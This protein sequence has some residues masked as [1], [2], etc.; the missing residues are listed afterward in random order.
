MTYSYFCYMRKSQES[1]ERQML[2]LDSQQQKARECFPGLDLEFIAEARSARK[3]HNRPLFAGMVE[4]L[5]RGERQGI[6]SWHPDRLS[7][8]PTDAGL[9]VQLLLD[10]IIKDLRFGSYTFINNPEGIMMLQIA[11]S[12]SQYY[13]AKLSQ[14]VKRGMDRK[15]QIG[16]RGGV[17]P[18]G[19]RNT[20]ERPRGSRIIVKD[21]ERFDLVRNIWRLVLAGGQTPR[22]I[23]KMVN[24]QWGYLS[25]VRRR[26]GGKPM[27]K[28]GFYKM[29]HNPF[30]CGRYEYPVGSGSWYQGAHEPMVTPEEF[31][32]VQTILGNDGPKCSP[33]TRTAFA[34]TGLFRCPCGYQITASDHRYVICSR[35]QRRFSEKNA[36]HCPTC[37]HPIVAMRQPERR[38]YVYYHCTR[39][40]RS[41]CRQPAVREARLERDIIALLRRVDVPSGVLAKALDYLRQTDAHD[42]G[43]V[44]TTEQSRVAAM[45]AIDDKLAQ[46]LDLRLRKQVTD[47][48]YRRTRSALQEERVQLASTV[49][50]DVERQRRQVPAQTLYFASDLCRRFREADASGKRAL[51]TTIGLNMTLNNKKACISLR[52]PFRLLHDVDDA[53]GA[54]SSPI[55]HEKE[56]AMEGPTAVSDVLCP[57]WC[58]IVDQL[59]TY[60]QSCDPSEVPH[61]P[62][63]TRPQ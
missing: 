18:V 10:G 54:E 39:S 46:L 3:P 55:E 34:F 47:E 51:L 35:C 5:Q 33:Q 36:Q 52:K 24:T 17:A 48:E 19:Y 43:A 50:T 8:N 14:D 25:P 57:R 7:R 28:T 31:N 6:V 26:A 61:F 27:S 20:P 45:K 40:G 59:R 4:R 42:H 41:G 29:L 22:A 63:I 23:L 58:A 9:L 32:R 1:D 11:L 44:A 60:C 30:Y 2:S 13:S 12:Q 38:R 16:W 15:A 49:A 62:D 56:Q 21:P 37:K 53:T